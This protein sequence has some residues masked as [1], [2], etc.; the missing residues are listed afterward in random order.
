MRRSKDERMGN[1]MNKHSLSP[2]DRWDLKDILTSTRGKLAKG[3]NLKFVEAMA[4]KLMPET[5][6]TRK[7]DALQ[8]GLKLK[9]YLLLQLWDKLRLLRPPE[10]DPRDYIKMDV[11]EK[12]E[13]VQMLSMTSPPISREQLVELAK[14]LNPSAITAENATDWEILA[15]AS[16]GASS[17]TPEGLTQELEE[18][19]RLGDEGMRDAVNILARELEHGLSFKEEPINKLF[20]TINKLSL[21]S[22]NYQWCGPSTNIWKN[23]V[24]GNEK[25]YNTLDALARDHDFAYLSAGLI[26]DQEKRHEAVVKSDKALIAGATQIIESFA[27]TLADKDIRENGFSSID[28]LNEAQKQIADARRYYGFDLTTVGK[29]VAF[30]GGAREA[31]LGARDAVKAIIREVAKKSMRQ[32][33]VQ[34]HVERRATLRSGAI[35]AAALLALQARQEEKGRKE[36]V[37]ITKK[38]LKAGA[39]VA[40]A[41]V[42]GAGALKEKPEITQEVLEASDA[43]RVI[44]MISAKTSPIITPLFITDQLRLTEK[45]KENKLKALGHYID[46]V[47]P[48]LPVDVLALN[49]NAEDFQQRI[50]EIREKYLSVNRFEPIEDV[51]PSQANGAQKNIIDALGDAKEDADIEKVIDDHY[52]TIVQLKEK[53]QKVVQRNRGLALKDGRLNPK[54]FTHQE[55]AIINVAYANPAIEA[56]FFNKMSGD[57]IMPRGKPKNKVSKPI[58]VFNAELKKPIDA[59]LEIIVTVLDRQRH[60]G[61]FHPLSLADL[62]TLVREN[63]IPF[64]Y[65]QRN[66]EEILKN[67]WVYPANL[68]RVFNFIKNQDNPEGFLARLLQ[69]VPPQ[70]VP[71]PQTPVLGQ[72]LLEDEPRKQPSLNVSSV[73]EKSPEEKLP[74]NMVQEE[75]RIIQRLNPDMT[76]EEAAALVHDHAYIF[77]HILGHFDK[78]GRHPEL[79]PPEEYTIGEFI[80]K[81]DDIFLQPLEEI[82]GY[83]I[84]K[85]KEKKSA[86]ADIPQQQ[87]GTTQTTPIDAN[88]LFPMKHLT[89]T[90]AE[91]ESVRGVPIGERKA[92]EFPLAN[93]PIIAERELRPMLFMGSAEDVKQSDELQKDNVRFY[94]HFKWI[95]DGSQYSDN[96]TK[97]P[98][99]S[100]LKASGNK[101]H[102]AQKVN[103]ALKMASP[104]YI[105]A[106]YRKPVMP[107]NATKRMFRQP[108]IPDVQRANLRRMIPVS[109]R[110][111]MSWRPIQFYND[112]APT[113]FGRI[114]GNSGLENPSVVVGKLG[115]ARV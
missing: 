87:A 78:I 90:P 56:M 82:L 51:A 77:A 12:E 62:V 81:H 86:L 16:S 96:N 13:L 17:T 45:D 46:Q 40:V 70:E 99:E 100:I 43:M 18:L 3:A 79:Y 10:I 6:N 59:Q 114:H 109:E 41:S 4:R 97:L 110:A 95:T 94:E 7:K 61:G 36:N 73:E 93:P 50:G 101:L 67:S 92:Q 35:G 113:P 21:T 47:Y 64:Q 103:E 83:M 42:I 49:P 15:Q 30:V 20:M 2:L 44:E 102:Q 5:Y 38:A 19:T 37:K 105:G 55:N 11:Q 71:P 76:R 111:K 108:M 8:D 80:H 57:N 29:A 58:E 98:W 74:P 32:L 91:W 26:D 115:L 66:Y 24:N 85:T 72:S 27:Q 69:E 88:A 65:I 48:N 33:A 89:L 52:E 39:G 54:F 112:K 106:S 31:L 75:R 25:A 14:Y 22:P 34:E 60:A 53:I 28:P 63:P 9:D 23:I 104:L 68:Q 1:L 107:S 84:E